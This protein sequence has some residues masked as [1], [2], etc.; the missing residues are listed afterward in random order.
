MLEVWYDLFTKV[1]DKHLPIKK[2]VLSRHL[3]QPD[4]INEEIL[5]AME[6]RDGFAFSEDYTMQILEK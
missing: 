1:V 4:W 6:M 2:D 3:S 5:N